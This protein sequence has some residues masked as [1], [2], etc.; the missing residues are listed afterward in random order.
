[1]IPVLLN[2]GVFWSILHDTEEYSSEDEI[3][4]PEI[5]MSLFPEKDKL[6]YERVCNEHGEARLWGGG[7]CDSRR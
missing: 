7:V 5:D 4:Y 1:M 6:G 3:V 2:V